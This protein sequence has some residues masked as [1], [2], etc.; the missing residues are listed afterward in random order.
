MRLIKAVLVLATL[1][2]FAVG[3]YAIHETLPAETQVVLPGPDAEAL[4]KYLTRL[5]PYE[6]WQLWPGK[7]KLYEGREPHGSLL[8]TYVNDRAINS[9]RAKSGMA[10]GSVIVKENYTP[11]KKL[12]AITV[13]YKISGY[14]PSGGDYFWAKYGPDWSVQA[15]GKVNACIECHGTRSDNDYIFTGKVK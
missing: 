11:D 3:A 10:D 13:M 12:S 4:A 1:M 8:T 6:G 9:I 14:N 2:C 5:N 15:S 7:G